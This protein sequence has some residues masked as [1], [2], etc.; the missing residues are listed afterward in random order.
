MDGWM[1]VRKE[2]STDGRMTVTDRDRTGRTMLLLQAGVHTDRSTYR[3]TH[4]GSHEDTY[5]GFT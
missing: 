3:Q 5:A 2:G 4:I 1:N